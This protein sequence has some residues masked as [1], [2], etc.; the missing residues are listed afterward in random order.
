M[1]SSS[2]TRAA[3][4]SAWSASLAAE[5][6][7]SV[8][9]F[10]VW[11]ASQSS[12]AASWSAMASETTA[13]MPVAYSPK[14]ASSSATIAAATPSIGI[15]AS[16][17]MIAAGVSRSS[18][19]SASWSS[20]LARTSALKPSTLS[21]LARVS[22]RRTSSWASSCAARWSAASRT[23]ALPTSIA[24]SM[25]PE[26]SSTAAKRNA[27]FTA[28]GGEVHE[29]ARRVRDGLDTALTRTPLAGTRLPDPSAANRRA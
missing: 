14:A 23:P 9:S 26:P 27:N 2:A 16:S 10:A 25:P 3:S 5:T 6:A 11:M 19:S 21:S 22:R 8:V 12:R 1:A 7:A 28:S 29:D 4:V 24:T 18:C 20:G 15:V 17:S 13:R